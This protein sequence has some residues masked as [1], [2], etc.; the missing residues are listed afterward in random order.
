MSIRVAYLC[1]FGTINGGENSMLSV[2]PHLENRGFHST[3]VC[4]AS[5]PLASRLNELGIDHQPFQ[6]NEAGGRRK[7]LEPLR[8]ELFEQIAA[9][10]VELVH[11]NSLS[12]SRIL[13]PIQRPSGTQ[14]VGHLRDIIKLNRTVL[15]D[16]SSLDEIYCVSQATREFHIGQGLSADNSYVIHNGVDTDYFYPRER[17]RDPLDPIRLLFVGQL[18]M[19]K[20][21]DVLLQVVHR[22]KQSGIEVVLDIYGECHSRKE[23]A[24]LH[25]EQLHRFVRQNQLE[26]VVRFHGRTDD[27]RQAYWHADVL[28]H[29]ARQE[30]WGRVLLEAAGCGL[31]IIATDVGGTSEMFSNREILLVPKDDVQVFSDAIGTVAA[32]SQLRAELGRKA[33]DRVE[34]SS[35]IDCAESIAVRYQT[36][37]GHPGKRLK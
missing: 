28:V 13:G 2:I 16:I 33:R 15:R 12:V 17:Q 23:E 10:N 14:F 5:S 19:R 18:V 11:A 32:S 35:S 1:E 37:C 34:R 4:P 6:W 25:V 21:V 22:V 27:V 8:G 24:K 31:A 29:S 20:G 36:L 7:P 9:W 3:V 26:E 30:P